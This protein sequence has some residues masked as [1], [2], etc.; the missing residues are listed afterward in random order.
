[1]T[2]VLGAMVALAG[3]LTVAAGATVFQLR[4]SDPA[5]NGLAE[6]FL[7]FTMLGLWGAIAVMLVGAGARPPR[8]PIFGATLNRATVVVFVVAVTSQMA[9]LTLLVGRNS[10][11]WYRLLLQLGV[12]LA[13]AA[14]IAHVLWRGFGFA[15]PTGVATT[16]MATLAIAVSLVPW[17]GV[18]QSRRAVTSE[19]VDPF[20]GVEFPALVVAGDSAA[21]AAESPAEALRHQP[22]N[23]DRL[24]LVD[25]RFEMFVIRSAQ[26]ADGER[27]VRLVD[28]EPDG[29]PDNVRR[30]L[31]RIGRFDADPGRDSSIRARLAAAATM[32]D[33]L[34]A[35]RSR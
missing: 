19:A 13:P 15:I 17:P 3:L 6:A 32:A 2:V 5:G 31:L 23:D 34:E 35:L 21:T 30:V 20:E 26:P 4:S 11:G 14:A 1:M 9:G 7:A 28:W 24:I 18:L 33:F 27:S 16:G 8:Q 25:S 29:T 12:I 22:G 10:E